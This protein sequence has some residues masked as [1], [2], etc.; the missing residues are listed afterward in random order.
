MPEKEEAKKKLSNA[1]AYF[2]DAAVTL[3][4][5]WE[6][7]EDS[8]VYLDDPSGKYPFKESLDDVVFSI[9]Q[10]SEAVSEE[11]FPKTPDNER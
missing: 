4:N 2:Y 6:E 3:L 9:G 1:V 7:S 11:L 10:W 8:E 5:T